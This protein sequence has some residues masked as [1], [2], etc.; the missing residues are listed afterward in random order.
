MAM[1]RSQM[2]ISHGIEYFFARLFALIFQLLPHKA[3]IELGARLG[4]AANN[5]WMTRHKIIIQNLEIAFGDSMQAAAREELSRDIFGNIGRTMAE[6]CRYPKMNKQR[7]LDL[8]DSEGEETFQEVLDYGKGGLLT[9]SHFG[10]WELIGAYINALGYPVD[11]LVRGQH[12]R[13]VDDYLSYLRRC[14]G[15]RVIHSERG[16]MKEILRALKNNRQVAIVSDQHAGSQGIVIKFFGRLVS[17]PRAPASLSVKTGAPIVTGQ[18]IRNQDH[19][20][21]CIF[22]KPIYPNMEADSKEEIFRLT[23]LFTMRIEQVIRKRPELWLWTHRRFKYV[24]EQEQ[25]EGLYV[26]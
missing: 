6:I 22:D 14:S 1:S 24:P 12:N 8:V 25:I 9:G 20:H 5:L 18:I 16:G 4:R 7:I 26:E 21:H 3:A 10:N 2:K 13:Y 19:T 17:V 15:V 23:K 11:F